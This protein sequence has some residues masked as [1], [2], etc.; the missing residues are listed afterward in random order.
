MAERR[1]FAKTIIDSDAFLDMP[2]SAQA[3]YFHLSM[4]ADDE[5]FINNPKKIQRMTGA[6]DDDFKLLIAKN[7]VI[8]FESGIVVIKHW[9]IHNYIRADR[10]V[11]TKYKEERGMLEIKDNGAYTISEAIPELEDMDSEDK[12][13][14]A[15]K[16]STLPYSFSYKIKRAFEGKTCPVCGKKMT[17]SLKT[18]MPTVQHNMPISKG[19]VHEL[20]NISVICESCNVSIRD[21]ETG[22]LNNAEVVD[23]WDRINEAERRKINWFQ[24]PA[25]LWQT[26]GRQMTDICP[27][28]DGIGKDSIGKYSL[29][30]VNNNMSGKPDLAGQRIEIVKYL[31]NKTG[32]EFRHS[33]KANARLIDAR[34][35]EGY[36]VDDFK[37]VI[38]T[39]TA[40]WKGTDMEQ[41][42]RPE[43]LFSASKFE[44][45]LNQRTIK[46]TSK[47]EFNNFA[48]HDYDMD[49]LTKRAK[50]HR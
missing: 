37:K 25:A 38:D 34:L 40:E 4:R 11:E 43:T 16:N 39:K 44:S 23:T 30:K 12:R 33:S 9:R 3:L 17:S 27:S 46:K 49:E 18:A 36:S 14:L 6:S 31:N 13:K 20:G 2:L 21:T 5:G 10:L 41:Y 42:L 8:P 7:F 28:N 19:G 48:Q 1:M 35:N 45:Y 32:K 22:C 50:G 24:D 15:Y 47:N 26:D 29:D